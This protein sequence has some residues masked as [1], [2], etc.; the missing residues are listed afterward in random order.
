[1]RQR[2][3]PGILM[4]PDAV[5]Y[6]AIL[7]MAKLEPLEV[8]GNECPSSLSEKQCSKRLSS[9]TKLFIPITALCTPINHQRDYT[10]A[11]FV[12]KI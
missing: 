5:P 12:S 8:Q 2:V 11:L 6:A 1:M 9:S 4:D 3:M 7:E 10:V